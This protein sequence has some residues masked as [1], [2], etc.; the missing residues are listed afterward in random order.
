MKVVGSCLKDHA[1][2]RKK[3]ESEAV[4]KV[5]QSPVVLL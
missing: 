1:A 2:N 3:H 4:T 5:K